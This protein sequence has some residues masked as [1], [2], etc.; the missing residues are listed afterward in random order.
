MQA[1]ISSIAVKNHLFV[2]EIWVRG[3]I[4]WD[5]T[6]N[7]GLNQTLFSKIRVPISL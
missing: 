3:C 2:L 6:V 1:C 7:S 5:V 4:S